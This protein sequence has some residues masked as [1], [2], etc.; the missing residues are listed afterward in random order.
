MAAWGIDEHRIDTALAAVR[1]EPVSEPE[2]DDLFA[3]AVWSVLIEPGDS[4]A[5]KLIAAVGADR[6]ARMIIDRAPAS[7]LVEA[8]EGDITHEKA[9]DALDRWLPRL[10]SD[11]V[12]RSLE[13]AARCRA[14][15]V[16]PHDRHW[17]EGFAALGPSEPVLLWA[18]GDTALLRRPGVAIVGARAATGYG[19]H[20]AMEF[21]AGLAARGVAIISGGAYGIDGMAHR[22]ALASAADTIAVLAGGVDRLYPSGHDALLTRVIAD[23]LVIGEAPCGSAPTK[24]RFLQR[25]RVIAALA[26]ATVVVEA[27]HRSGAL[28][29]ANHALDIGRPVGAVPGAITSAASAGCHRIIREGFAVC[30]TSVTEIMQLAFE[31]DGV[32]ELP[33]DDDAAASSGDDPVHTRVLDALR[34]RRGQ[35]TLDIARAV[36]ES[37][38]RVRAVL[39]LLSID[40]RALCGDDALW[41]RPENRAKPS[42]AE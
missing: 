21:T 14:R 3:R 29:T 34:P 7:A 2:R 26:R 18:R 22:A 31:G 30:V 23:G 28:S 33:A 5:G 19:E 32:L 24:W 6:A 4:V 20:V 25:N 9:I 39:G 38:S 40:D 42:S 41:R 8:C 37:E 16:V 10:R 17:P 27:G 35:T 11:D 12:L 36:G 13:N 15:M 1:A